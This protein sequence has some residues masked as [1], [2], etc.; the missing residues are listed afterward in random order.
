MFSL[1]G[2]LEAVRRGDL[3]ERLAATEACTDANAL[4]QQQRPRSLLSNHRGSRLERE[5]FYV[6]GIYGV[7]T[8]ICSASS[9]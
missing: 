4:L 6:H 8:R 1:K 9:A 5:A 7:R 3:L 2:A